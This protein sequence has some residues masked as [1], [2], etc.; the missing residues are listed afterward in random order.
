L[1]GSQKDILLK[2]LIHLETMLKEIVFLRHLPI[3]SYCFQLEKN[4]EMPQR[5]SFDLTKEQRSQTTKM[6]LFNQMQH[7]ANNAWSCRFGIA[8]SH[9]W[10]RDV[11][12]CHGMDSEIIHGR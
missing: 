4:Q 5:E 2:G 6:L 12:C 8:A 3:F 9:V 1:S 10:W 11:G 7:F